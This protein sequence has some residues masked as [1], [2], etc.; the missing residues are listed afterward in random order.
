[1]KRDGLTTTE[2]NEI[3][4]NNTTLLYYCFKLIIYFD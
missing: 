3:N 2:I 1:M 4:L